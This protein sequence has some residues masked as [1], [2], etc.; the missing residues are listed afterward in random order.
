[1][2]NNYRVEYEKNNIYKVG[3]RAIAFFKDAGK[4]ILLILIVGDSLKI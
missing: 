4:I 2:Y 1:M 3:D